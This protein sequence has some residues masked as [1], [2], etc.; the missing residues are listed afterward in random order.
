MLASRKIKYAETNIG[1]VRLEL[2]D[3][4]WV[5]TSN[6]Q[7]QANVKV[8]C[9]LV[10]QIHQL[11]GHD[12]Q[13]LPS[14]ASIVWQGKHMEKYRKIRSL[15]TGKMLCLD[16]ENFCKCWNSITGILI[17]YSPQG[18]QTFWFLWWVSSTIYAMHLVILGGGY[19]LE[20]DVET[21]NSY[22]YSETSSSQCDR[23]NIAYQAISIPEYH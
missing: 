13:R 16:I 6:H 20:C 12:E 5:A 17:H 10:P 22:T 21:L 4:K 14:K 8:F 1:R 23:F 19:L 7:E 3:I 11:Y 15:D 18:D 2:L 9:W